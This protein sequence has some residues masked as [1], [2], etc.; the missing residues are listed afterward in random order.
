MRISPADKAFSDCIHLAFNHTCDRCGRAGRVEC[1]HIHSRRH[2]TIR[3]C[4][5]N[6]IAKCHTCHRW[7]HEHPTE[8]GLWFI[9]EYGQG[10]EDI[11]IE[12][13]NAKRKITKLEEKDI[14]KH[15]REQAKI[16]K[17]KREEGETGFITFESWQ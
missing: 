5:E 7:W 13:K 10:R 3:W 1:S 12:K 8:S 14:A 16:L 6:A 11:L 15:Y 2:R 4:I 17:K 9:A